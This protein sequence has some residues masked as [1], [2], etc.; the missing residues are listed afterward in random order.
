[1]L[2]GMCRSSRTCCCS[3]VSCGWKVCTTRSPLM[4]WWRLTS[5]KMSRMRGALGHRRCSIGD[6]G[7]I[8]RCNAAGL[9]KH[10][11][12]F[13]HLLHGRSQ[14][15]VFIAGE[16]G[17]ALLAFDGDRS[18][19]GVET[20]TGLRGRGSL[21]RYER[22]FILLLARDLVLPREN[23]SRFP[24]QHLRHG[25][26]ESVAIHAID[27]FLIPE[28]VAPARAIEI[29]RKPRHRFGTAGQYAIEVADR[30]FLIAE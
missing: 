18:N 26:H 3:G 4:R 2:A 21:L 25:T 19:F 22:K 14:E 27:Q 23:L 7:R 8:G 16:N 5:L 28:A 13:R 15:Q 6:A 10:G 11:S 12:Q 17:G 1:M 30:N 20:S 24:H 9:G 29:I